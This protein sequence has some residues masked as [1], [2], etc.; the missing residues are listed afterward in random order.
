MYYG[1]RFNSITHLVGAAL[2]LMGLGALVTVGVNSGN[3]KL[4]VSYTIFGFSMVLLYTMST[5][6]HSFHPVSLKR[7]FRKLD[8]I[9]IYILI[10]GTYTPYLL[11]ALKEN[12]GIWILT[13]VWTMAV[14]GICLDVF[15][16]NRNETLQICIYLLM[17]WTVCLDFN[18]IYAA[19][20]I[21]GFFWLALGGACYC[22]GLIFYVLDVLK[23]FN[24]AH[25]I[26]HL[27]VMAGT[28]FHFISII[29]YV[30]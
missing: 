21:L 6:Y 20:S 22:I 18:G 30:R 10:A 4:L 12:K 1:E 26:W 9:A 5:L 27:W 8:H 15:K 16:R 17:G 14:I 24:H 28:F 3:T 25:G 7:L 23:R 11:V 2:S 19:I 13:F 29:N